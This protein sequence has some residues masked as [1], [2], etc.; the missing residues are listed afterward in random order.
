MA[1]TQQRLGAGRLAARALFMRA[2]WQAWRGRAQ[3]ATA[4]CR[5]AVEHADY[6]RADALRAHLTLPGELYYE[7]LARIHA[8]LKPATY[9]EIGVAAGESL[10]RVLPQTD[11]IGVDPNPQLPA[12]PGPRQRI[13]S[14][15]SDE[16]FA[17]HDL[18][19]EFGGRAV[20]MAFIDGMHHFEFALRDFINIERACTAGSVILIHDCYPLDA[21]T[22]EREQRTRFWSG[23]IWRLML[24]LREQRPDLTVHTIA[25]PATGLGI[26]LN[27]DPSSPLAS[28]CAELTEAYRARDFSV[29]DG[30]KPQALGLIPN[31]WPV[32]R[33][34]LDGRGRTSTP[35]V[36]E[37]QP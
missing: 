34:L 19:A 11:V 8:H 31:E 32:I 33:A 1:D 7:V 37:T 13:F 6:A 35:L 10:E 15:T 23:D 20:E 9:L 18:R 5:R 14:A 22:A 16:F 4:L 17:R 12:P 21:R 26:V 3:E 30:R 29:L 25:A 27:P 2:R 28:R 24:L 36:A